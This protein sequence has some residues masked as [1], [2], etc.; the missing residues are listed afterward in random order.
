MLAKLGG[1][2]ERKDRPPGKIVLTL[3]HLQRLFDM[4]TTEALL[5]NHIQQHGALPPRIAA[6]LHGWS[7]PDL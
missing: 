5:A 7:P 4:L 6:L 1:W 2:Q 3:R